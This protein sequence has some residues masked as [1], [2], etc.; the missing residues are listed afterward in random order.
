MLTSM[1][2]RMD[3]PNTVARPAHLF[4]LYL[5]FFFPWGLELTM[6]RTKIRLNPE[7]SHAVPLTMCYPII[8]SHWLCSFPTPPNRQQLWLPSTMDDW[9]RPSSLEQVTQ[10]AKILSLHIAILPSSLYSLVRPSNSQSYPCHLQTTFVGQVTSW[11]GLV[12]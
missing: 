1:T 10:I 4:V 3:L 6:R 11:S 7:N 5:F 2:L 12:R 9:A 8:F